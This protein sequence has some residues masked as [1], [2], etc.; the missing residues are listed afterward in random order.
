[1]HGLP[2]RQVGPKSHYL[3]TLSGSKMAK[4]RLL[5]SGHITRRQDTLEK[6]TTLGHV[7]GN[8]KRVHLN[9]DYSMKS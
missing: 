8:R 3:Q 4:L 5:Y 9:M 6:R 7:E 1:M 2:G